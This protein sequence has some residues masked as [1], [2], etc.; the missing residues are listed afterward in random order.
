M[1]NTEKWVIQNTH[2]QLLQSFAIDP[3][4]IR[5]N[6]FCPDAPGKTKAA[7]KGPLNLLAESKAQVLLMALVSQVPTEFAGAKVVS[8]AQALSAVSDPSS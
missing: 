4:Q 3:K 7:E 1:N 2:G 6:W 8:L 5:I